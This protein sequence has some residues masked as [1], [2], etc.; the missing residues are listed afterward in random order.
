MRLWVRDFSSLSAVGHWY[1]GIFTRT[2]KT[3]EEHI[4]SFH[5]EDSFV[6]VPP[7][8][9]LAV[10]IHRFG[11]T[12]AQQPK[13]FLPF[14]PDVS[15]G[16]DF[17]VFQCLRLPPACFR[18]PRSQSITDVHARLFFTCLRDE[19][20]RPDEAS[21]LLR[22][23]FLP[24]ENKSLSYFYFTARPWTTVR[25]DL[26]ISCVPR[27]EVYITYYDHHGNAAH[28]HQLTITDS[29]Y[30]TIPLQRVGFVI[31]GRIVAP[32]LSDHN[33]IRASGAISIHGAHSSHGP[34]SLQFLN[35][36]EWKSTLRLRER[37]KDPKKAKRRLRSMLVAGWQSQVQAGAAHGKWPV[38]R[39]EAYSPVQ[40][41]GP[42][43]RTRTVVCKATLDT[44]RVAL[45]N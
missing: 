4:C 10:R 22:R 39:Q 23:V 1:G 13:V 19:F 7:D 2:R 32:N 26:G 24:V 16:I 43:P 40:K 21:P 27:V 42:P 33:L 30:C 25:I 18:P 36:S 3:L 14:C 15:Q 5:G 11:H 6:D 41:G 35:N 8:H 12:A 17:P 31:L 37:M 29:R 45:C 20:R 9:T 38:Q 28:G 34:V 44:R